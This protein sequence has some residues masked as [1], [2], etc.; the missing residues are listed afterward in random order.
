MPVVYEQLSLFSLVLPDETTAICLMGR[1]ESMA[2]KPEAWMLGLVPD[3]EYVVDVGEHPL[4]LRPAGLR[5]EEI[6]PGHHY[7][8]YLIGSRVYA[9]IFVGRYDDG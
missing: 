7:R 6:E 5:E 9:G 8:H 4:V 3:G 2:R 1:T